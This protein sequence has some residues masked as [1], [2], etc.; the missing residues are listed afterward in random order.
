MNSRLLRYLV[1]AKSFPL[2]TRTNERF[3]HFGVNEVTVERIQLVQPKIEAWRIGITTEITEISHR[4]K[5]AIEFGGGEARVCHNPAQSKG[6]GSQT[7]LI[8]TQARPEFHNFCRVP[9]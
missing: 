2:L 1:G 9:N 6:A 8:S 3:D 4:Y 7:P 5:R